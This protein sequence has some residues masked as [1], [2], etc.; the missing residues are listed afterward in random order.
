MNTGTLV[1]MAA[2]NGPISNEDVAAYGPVLRKI[3]QESGRRLKP[4]EVVELAKNPRS[5]LH[6]F[7]DWN[8]ASAAHKHRVWRARQLIN[9]VRVVVVDENGRRRP[10]RLFFNVRLEDD[11]KSQRV[12]VA[13]DRIMEDSG[14]R[15]QVVHQALQEFRALGEKYRRYKELDDI[16]IVVAR[17]RAQFKGKAKKGRRKLAHA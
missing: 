16:R 9:H 7:F 11:E 12:Y 2:P 3:E 13:V 8:D 6:R 4:A 10:E 5:P 17:V 15:S 1:Y 14:L